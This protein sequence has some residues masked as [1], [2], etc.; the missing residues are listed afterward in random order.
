MEDD[1][2]K[3]RLIL[4]GRTKSK[5]NIPMWLD[6]IIEIKRQ[7]L[8]SIIAITAVLLVFWII[9]RT[10]LG[11]EQERRLRLEKELERRRVDNG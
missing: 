1:V 2:S 11:K 9:D 7:H 4:G 3:E 10:R 8:L 5:G 6:T